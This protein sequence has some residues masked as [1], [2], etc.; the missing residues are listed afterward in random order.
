MAPTGIAGTKAVDFKFTLFSKAGEQQTSLTELRAG[1]AVVIDF[2]APWCKACPDA[3][4]KLEALAKTSHAERCVFLLMCVD[5]TAEEA[6]QFASEHG[7]EHC[8][9]AWVEDCDMP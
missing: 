2:F 8:Q 3:A 7:I 4:Q 1:K 6:Q 9:V 5:G